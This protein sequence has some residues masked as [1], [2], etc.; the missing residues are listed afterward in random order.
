MKKILSLAIAIVMMMAVAVPAFAGE[1]NTSGNSADTQI[2]T[3]LVK[4]D[5]TD[6]EFFIVT[7]P[8]EQKIFWGK[9]STD[10]NYTVR[11]QL[12]TGSCLQVVVSDS[13]DGYVMT[14]TAGAT[15]AYSL[16]DTT[17]KASEEVVG[18]TTETVKVNVS[19]DAWANA[20]VDAYSDILTFT[21]S[22]VAL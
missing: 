8:A 11:S 19:A 13:D 12:A 17:Y 5:G 6:A 3:L 7:I 10:V 21:A 15:L 14:N 20:A 9:E 2:E 1:I 22:V 4:E 18:T 16:A